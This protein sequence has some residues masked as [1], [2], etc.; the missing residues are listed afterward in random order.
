MSLN[1]DLHFAEQKLV[2]YIVV[3]A[4]IKGHTISCKLYLPMCL[5]YCGY[6]YIIAN[7]W[8]LA[9]LGRRGGI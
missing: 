7:T 4:G 9:C 5:D 3:L 6:N 1:C 2:K 8:R